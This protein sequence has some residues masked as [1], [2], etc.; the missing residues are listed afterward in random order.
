MDPGRSDQ[1]L[2]VPEG[3]QPAEP[4]I[5]LEGPLAESGS[6]FYGYYV[7]GK[8]LDTHDLDIFRQEDSSTAME[9]FA[10]GV[11]LA[12]ITYPDYRFLRF[13]DE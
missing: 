7:E 1:R 5:P 4:V 12:S 9:E 11:D 2:D 10:P 6:D 13:P 3:Y 8:G